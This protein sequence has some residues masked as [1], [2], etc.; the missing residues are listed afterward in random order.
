MHVPRT[1]LR[2]C[3]GVTHATLVCL[4]LMQALVG[5]PAVP[6]LVPTPSSEVRGQHIVDGQSLAAGGWHAHSGRQGY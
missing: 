4:D 6:T 5:V 1:P 3:L 2:N